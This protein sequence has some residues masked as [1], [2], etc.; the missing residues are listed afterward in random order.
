MQSRESLR[1][2]ST[3]VLFAEAKNGYIVATNSSLAQIA[4]KENTTYNPI[5]VER[6]LFTIY[7]GDSEVTRCHTRNGEEI[8]FGHV[9]RLIHHVL[10]APLTNLC[11]Q[12]AVVDRSNS[13]VVLGLQTARDEDED[14]VADEN[15]VVGDLVTAE[16]LSDFEQNLSKWRVL[17]RYRLRGEG[18]RICSGDH[19]IL[20]SMSGDQAYLHVARSLEELADGGYEVNCGPVPEG[21]SMVAFDPFFLT[22]TR[23]EEERDI[24]CG[25]CVV[26]VHKEENLA[27]VADH[28]YR[29]CFL[30]ANTRAN[31]VP[32]IV[33]YFI[34]ES[35]ERMRGGTVMCSRRDLFRLRSV[36]NSQYLCIREQQFGGSVD[37]RGQPGMAAEYDAVLAPLDDASSMGT[38]LAFHQAGDDQSASLKNGGRVFIEVPKMGGGGIWLGAGSQ[39]AWVGGSELSVNGDARTMISCSSQ[40]VVKDGFEVQRL[41]VT[42]EQLVLSILALLGPVQSLPDQLDNRRVTHDQVTLVAENLAQ[43]GRM[44]FF[45]KAADDSATAFTMSDA[46]R[47]LNA[48][49]Q[50]LLFQLGVPQIVAQI[51]RCIWESPNISVHSLATDDFLYADA[52]DETSPRYVAEEAL[53][54]QYTDILCVI[55]NALG[56]ILAIVKNQPRHALGITNHLQFLNSCCSQLPMAM[57]CVTECYRDNKLLLDVPSDTKALE[58]FLS[59]LARKKWSDD[60]LRLVALFAQCGDD[61]LPD[62]QLKILHDLLLNPNRSS[63]SLLP[64]AC[65]RNDDLLLGVASTFFQSPPKDEFTFVSIRKIRSMLP[66]TVFSQGKSTLL[67][68]L[69]AQV[70]LLAAVCS[71]RNS[72]CAK[73]VLANLPPSAVLA[74]AMSSAP[75]I[76]RAAFVRL[77]TTMYVDVDGADDVRD[78][79]SF[80]RHSRAGGQG[81]ASPTYRETKDE[82]LHTAKEF[83]C[84][85]F[86]A[87]PGF[88]DVQSEGRPSMVGAVAKLCFA[89]VTRGLFEEDE[90]TPLISCVTPYIDSRYDLTGKCSTSTLNAVQG[91]DEVLLTKLRL[92][93]VVALLADLMLAQDAF[94]LADAFLTNDTTPI[95]NQLLSFDKSHQFAPPSKSND[96]GSPFDNLAALAE[97]V[98]F[99]KV[100]PISDSE[101]VQRALLEALMHAAKY[102]NVPLRQGIIRLWTKLCN[103][104]AALAE[105]ARKV[106][107]VNSRENE[108]MFKDIHGATK[109][110]ASLARAP[111]SSLS[112]KVCEDEMCRL[113]RIACSH[114]TGPAQEKLAM[115]RHAGLADVLV[116]L[117]Q[118]VQ[119]PIADP[120][121]RMCCFSAVRLLQAL[122]QDPL[123]HERLCGTVGS[124]LHLTCHDVDILSL[125]RTL[126]VGRR[127]VMYLPSAVIRD[128]VACVERPL[129]ALPAV[130]LLNDILKCKDMSR[131]YIRSN[132]K[133]A[134]RYLTHTK[135][136][137]ELVNF[138][139]RWTGKLGRERRDTM[140]R[141]RDTYYSQ[142]GEMELHLASVNLLFRIAKSNEAVDPE[143]IRHEVFGP[144]AIADILEVVCNRTLP[145]VFRNHYVN[146]LQVLVVD[147]EASLGILMHHRR[148][149]EFLTMCQVDVLYLLLLLGGKAHTNG[150]GDFSI[151]RVQTNW[152][153]PTPFTALEQ[154]IEKSR[155]GLEAAVPHVAL[156]VLPCLRHIIVKVGANSTLVRP[157]ANSKLAAEINDVV[158][159]AADL[160]RLVFLLLGTKKCG[161]FSSLMSAQQKLSDFLVTAADRKFCGSQRWADDLD[162]LA[163]QIQAMAPPHAT[164]NDEDDGIPSDGMLTTIAGEWRSYVD[165]R[166]AAA[167]HCEVDNIFSS[168]AGFV[169]RSGEAGMTFVR[170]VIRSLPQLDPPE[171]IVVLQLCRQVAAL[172]LDSPFD[173]SGAIVP[174]SA[175][176]LRHM[177]E[178]EGVFTLCTAPADRQVFMI[179]WNVVPLVIATIS[180]P[181]VGVRLAAVRCAL[182][183]LSGGNPAVLQSFF[184]S[185]SFGGSG[186]PVFVFLR[187][188]LA[189][190]RESLRQY[191]WMVARGSE[192]TSVLADIET[193]TLQLRLLQYLCEGHFTTMQLYFRYQ[194]DTQVSVNMLEC[195][196]E[197]L[198]MAVRSVDGT[199]IDMV[200]QLV[201]TIAET[202][203]GPCEQNQEMFV[204]LDIAEPLVTL[205]GL[206]DAQGAVPPAKVYSLRR[207]ALIVLRSMIEGRMDAAFVTLYCGTLHYEK[208][209]N[210]MDASA[211]A[212]LAAGGHLD[213]PSDDLMGH[214]ARLG[215]AAVSRFF[216][217][218]EKDELNDELSI[219]ADIFIIFK[220]IVDIE[221][222][223]ETQGKSHSFRDR[224]GLTVVKALSQTRFEKAINVEIGCIEI[225]RDNKL[226]RAYF[227]VPRAS[228]NN[229][230]EATKQDLI[231]SVDRSSDSSKHRDYLARCFKMMRELDYYREV[232]KAPLL[233]FVHEYAE[234]FDVIALLLIFVL[235]LYMLVKIEAPL[236]IYV[237]D[238]PTRTEQVLDGLGI[239][240][241]VLQSLL[242]VNFFFGPLR[243]HLENCWTMW[244]QREMQDSLQRA[245]ASLDNLGVSPGAAEEPSVTPWEYLV[246][247]AYFTF[248]YGKFY[249]TVL[250]LLASILGFAQSK[251]WYTIQLLQITT[252]SQLLYNVVLAVVI[253]GPSLLL[254]LVLMLIVIFI[255]ANIS[256]Y[257][258][259][260]HFDPIVADN[261][262]FH[263]NSLWN[264][265][266][267]H[268]DSVR[269]GGGI[270]DNVVLKWVDPASGAGY[271]LIAFQLM[272]FIIVILLFLN[273]VFGII[274]DSFGQLRGEREFIDTDQTTKCFI[275]G[276]DQNEF[277]RAVAGG[278]DLHIRTE[279]NM[280]MY[281]LFMHYV[282]KKDPTE[283]NGQE[284]FVAQCMA[285]KEP[286][287]FPLG[288]A[289]MLPDTVGLPAEVGGAVAPAS[290]QLDA[291]L[292]K[293]NEVLQRLDKL[294][295]AGGR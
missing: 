14:A 223:L 138:A 75:S 136:G 50:K 211:D 10:H 289:T 177:S 217:G 60:V 270:G 4:V 65:D 19:V 96:S 271:D 66:S 94:R 8:K 235:N 28:R 128:V 194:S 122:C 118:S 186:E 277:D 5:Q 255:F 33:E 44:C 225:L 221:F 83:V 286:S 212:F 232:R 146:L 39:S 91:G 150:S 156:A 231:K 175:I 233:S 167:P 252:K 287:F 7:P 178:E 266:V 267:V 237:T 275:C 174:V 149:H 41:P 108:G 219:G 133:A 31:P 182:V 180:S 240:L 48:G 3:I 73:T 102:D 195:L 224:V 69:V 295:Q 15:A 190:F 163:K 64:M 78:L 236:T 22:S 30:H 98:G 199:T 281:L 205:V 37:G 81:C 168:A 208:L 70:E 268:L 148:L 92:T 201:A 227:R 107:L 244:K 259:S 243:V 129:L 68:F 220:T 71:G 125:I 214:G 42:E 105:T 99:N 216:G 38:L 142:S 249:Q 126:F 283:L 12:H 285:R 169:L 80:I 140:L 134:W 248:S 291:V 147:D 228:R 34:V 213:V 158:D 215:S 171:Q 282:S 121:I 230:R 131:K 144:T 260:E 263:C 16:R 222:T 187:N 152:I 112:A 254:T 139:G 269:A 229:L 57:S 172:E 293:L 130:L 251:V 188:Q 143:A 17:P 95:P 155:S 272:F 242:F 56:L 209:G 185:P 234:E 9:V 264:C 55:N 159:A 160:A 137:C 162:G 204:A 24:R 110:L 290:A 246:R 35:E 86:R 288:K 104:P 47:S 67:T 262:G 250:Y 13:R 2:G 101:T 32:D 245:R 87:T 97:K 74:I 58:Y 11:D 257:N 51:I 196:A 265:W 247:S 170:S 54:V 6:S 189:K 181:D 23:P 115:I 261:T 135:P 119:V 191:Q 113:E 72:V 294:E 93:E 198:E 276:I 273:I 184:Q 173:E 132:Q 206:E 53:P 63:Q 46:G 79:T 200:T 256:F 18:E 103:V 274:V 279:H 192:A 241:I 166:I 238:P 176:Q 278:F 123:V 25:D 161:P 29:K 183:L 77:F 100:R 45:T 26:L 59:I 120:G 157:T 84:S 114:S 117:L 202:I 207:N 111:L 43:L 21:L 218:S 258:F 76:L 165:S 145:L 124:V 109:R 151:E 284:D 85:F 239:T 226:E 106:Q 154:N 193:I 253:N 62:G 52:V 49:G 280:W 116:Q 164:A 89:L 197:L 153:R 210:A 292:E 82:L 27:L 1:Y 88:G 127:S 141:Q 203:Q 20:Q 61:G 40:V 90:Y 179:D 36:A